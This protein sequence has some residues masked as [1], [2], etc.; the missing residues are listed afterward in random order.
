MDN[1]NFNFIEMFVVFLNYLENFDIIDLNVENLV[2]LYILDYLEEK[3]FLW[4][5]FYGING[6]N[7]DRIRRLILG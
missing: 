4:F 5:F 2:E 6:Y 3:I 7:I 1:E